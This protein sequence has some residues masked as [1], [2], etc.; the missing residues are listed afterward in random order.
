MKKGPDSFCCRMAAV[1]LLEWKD[2]LKHRATVEIDDPVLDVV[3]DSEG[4]MW[5]SLAS[6]K[7]RIVAFKL[8]EDKV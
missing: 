8:Q 5:T 1:V 4:M 6:S 2:G 7:E 3:F